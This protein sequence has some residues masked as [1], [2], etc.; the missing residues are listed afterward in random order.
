MVRAL[1]LGGCV[2]AAAALALTTASVSRSSS[3]PAAAQAAAADKVIVLIPKQTGDPFFAD[4]RRGATEAAKKLGYTIKYVGPATA[5]AAGQVST[6][7]NAIQLHPVAITIAADDP[8]AVAPSL[9]RAM[10]QGIAVSAYN[11]DVRKDARSFFVSQASDE[12]IAEGIADTMAAQTGG[13]GHFLLVSS[14]ATAPNQNLWNALAK[15]YMAKKYPKMKID[16]I[17]FGNDDPATVLK[18]TTSYLAGHKDLT[19]IIVT[20]GGMSGAVKAEQRVG[21]NPKKVPVAGLCIPSDVKAQIHAGLIK[22]CVLWSPADMGYATV[23]AID[24]FLAKKL[25]LKGKGKLKSGKLGTLAVQN[26]TVTVG[27]PFVFTK[28]NIDQFHF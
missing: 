23:Y 7:E 12:G 28:Q 1:F 11:A 24:A 20:G 8:N 3:T 25:A 27:K 19:G 18:I 6:I 2:A 4:V 15:K 13:K 22:N 26:G 5:D 21:L 14:T 17:I 10:Q 9:K 16:T